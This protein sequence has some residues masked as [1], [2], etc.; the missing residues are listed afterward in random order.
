MLSLS[1]TGGGSR[2]NL[3]QLV[4]YDDSNLLAYNNSSMRPIDTQPSMD[5]VEE[6]DLVAAL[7][8]EETKEPPLTCRSQHPNL[9]GTEAA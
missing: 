6:D 7:Q 8:N 5:T 1:I 9:F 2:H 4:D 3:P